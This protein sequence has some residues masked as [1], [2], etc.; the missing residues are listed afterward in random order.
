MS[1]RGAFEGEAAYFQN[2]LVEESSGFVAWET[3]LGCS[4]RNDS[5]GREPETV[6]PEIDVETIREQAFAEGFEQGCRTV[7]AE[8][9]QEREA[10]AALTASIEAL[11]REPTDALAALLAVTVER[12]VHQIVGEV[13]I[14][15]ISLVKR[16]EAA[17]A[18]IGEEVEASRLLVHPDD[19][20]LFARSRVPVEIA[21]DPS[22]ERGAVRLEWN[23]G[24]IEDG[25]SVR[26]ERLRA[27]LD[28]LAAPQ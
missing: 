27:A 6:R 21:A 3:P 1:D 7:E 28:G 12:L 18:L 8:V 23:R 25:P 24:W 22:L 9:A 2:I 19:L 10:I 11:Q 17:A 16:A 14:N 15:P 26:L 13:P 4:A 20:P 5:V